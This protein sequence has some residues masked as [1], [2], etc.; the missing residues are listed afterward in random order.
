[1][2]RCVGSVDIVAVALLL[3]TLGRKQA[4]VRRQ[5]CKQCSNVVAA[6][7]S[8]VQVLGYLFSGDSLAKVGEAVTNKCGELPGVKQ[9]LA[10]LLCSLKGAGSFKRSHCSRSKYRTFLC[11]EEEQ[12]HVSSQKTSSNRFEAHTKSAGI[13]TTNEQSSSGVAGA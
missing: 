1:V 4:K 2:R 7:L 10:V 13:F 9:A 5:Q 3:L 8:L 6:L 11:K 12:K